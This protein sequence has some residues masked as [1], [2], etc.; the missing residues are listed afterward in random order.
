MH[1]IKFFLDGPQLCIFLKLWLP[2]NVCVGMYLIFHNIF[3]SNVIKLFSEN[4][5]T[6]IRKTSLAH[7]PRDHCARGLRLVCTQLKR[8]YELEEPVVFVT[9]YFCEMNYISFEKQII[10]IYRMSYC[11][12]LQSSHM[13]WTNMGI[14]F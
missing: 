1:C 10:N 5:I 2:M 11:L 7:F 13:V 6:N 4:Y 14:N 9:L 3:Y 12:L 8:M